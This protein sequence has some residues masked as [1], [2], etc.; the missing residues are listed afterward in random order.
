VWSG[1]I[2]PKHRSTISQQS[3]TNQSAWKQNLVQCWDHKS[4]ITDASSQSQHGERPLKWKSLLWCTHFSEND[5]IWWNWIGHIKSSNDYNLTKIKHGWRTPYWKISFL[6]QRIVRLARN[7]VRRHKIGLQRR[8]SEKKSNFEDS[9]WRPIAI[10]KITILSYFGEKSSDVDEI[11]YAKAD[12]DTF[13]WTNNLKFKMAGGRHVGRWLN[14]ATCFSL[15]DAKSDRNEK[16]RNS[17]WQND[18][19]NY[20]NDNDNVNFIASQH[21]DIIGDVLHAK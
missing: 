16:F 6:S 8:S 3:Q 4:R 13:V 19:F 14:M 11:L 1:G 9:R 10:L 7:L 15:N 17:R 20:D 18:N 21:V 5:R 12:S 2:E